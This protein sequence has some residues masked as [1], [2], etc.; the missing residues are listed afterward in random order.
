MAAFGLILACA[1][2]AFAQDKPDRSALEQREQELQSLHEKQS[3]SAEA[4]AALKSEID[5]IAADRRK[6]NQDLIDTAARL[7][8]AE[9][10]I[11]GTETRLKP[12]DDNESALRKSL[13]GR[14]ATIAEVLAALQR[15]GRRPP[16]ALIASPEDALQAVRSAMVLGAVLPD[17][18][19]EVQALASDLTQ[20]LDLRKKIAAERERL[21]KEVVSLDG[22]RTRMAALV[23]ARQK[24]IAEREQALAAERAHA[25][26]LAKQAGD[27]TDL[28]ANLE[29]VLDPA[30]R[31]DREKTTRSSLSALHDPGRLAPAIAFAS[32]RGKVP[33]PVNGI[34]IRDYGVPDP[35]GSTERGVSFATR[36]GA[37]VTAPI[38][39]WVVYAGPF[40]SYG[41]LLI[42]NAGGGYHVLLAGMERISVD[43]GQFVLTGEPVAA[44][45]NGSHVAAI[46]ATGSSQPVLYV[47]IR[48]DGT[49]VD[50]GPW[51]AQGEGEKVRG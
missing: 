43:I 19:N 32:L 18:R 2:P 38:D 29:R 39:G 10:K 34:K 20:L 17:M 37:Q 13:D 24:Q 22:E 47:E 12:L 23:D 33:M 45:G 3:K 14:R 49:P 41:Q 11:A 46:L 1:A 50:P 16:P 31:A 36:A 42:L 21:T 40:R 35:S 7:R 26:E 51:W 8:D 30:T 15:M 48:K 44:M 4:E 5:K 28:I 27:L 6:L 9:S 25:G